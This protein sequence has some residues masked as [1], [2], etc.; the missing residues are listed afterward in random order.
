MFSK[1]GRLRGFLI[2]S[3][4]FP[5]I[6]AV[7]SFLIIN[8]SV[9]KL[10]KIKEFEKA[11]TANNNQYNIDTNYHTQESTMYEPS[12]NPASNEQSSDFLVENIDSE[13]NE[14]NNDINEGL[15]NEEDIIDLQTNDD[16]KLAEN[17]VDNKKENNFHET[18]VSEVLNSQDLISVINKLKNSLIEKKSLLKEYREIHKELSKKK[19][20]SISQ[21]DNLRLDQKEN[22]DIVSDDEIYFNEKES[23]LHKDIE[24]SEVPFLIDMLSYVDSLKLITLKDDFIDNNWSKSVHYILE[25]ILELLE[26]HGVKAIKLKQGDIPDQNLIKIISKIKSKDFRKGKIIKVIEEGY[27]IKNNVLRRAKVEV[28][29]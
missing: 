1:K 25:R 17:I 10:F 24:G 16:A 12:T 5:P 29:K 26:N 21:L 22:L 18:S 7:I 9:Y 11:Q 20:Y 4:F 2:C 15:I 14:N 27:T 3:L 19:K 13:I 23:N 6:G 8:K 28:G